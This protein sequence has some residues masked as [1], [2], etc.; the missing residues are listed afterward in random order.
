MFASEVLSTPRLTGLQAAQRTVVDLR[1][2]LREHAD[3]REQRAFL[4]FLAAFAAR[5]LDG[6]R[7]PDVAKSDSRR[8]SDPRAM[9]VDAVCDRAASESKA[10][11]GLPADCLL[12]GVRLRPRPE[13]RS[14]ADAE[15]CSE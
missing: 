5:G 14:G 10:G 1:R 15:R 11:A 13:G 6:S 4:E 8:S 12:V 7:R 2:M 9:V 3:R